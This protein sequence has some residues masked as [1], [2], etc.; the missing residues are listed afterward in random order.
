MLFRS[1]EMK[2]REGRS[3]SKPLLDIHAFLYVERESQKAI[4]IGKGGQRLKDVG[5]RARLSIERLLGVPVFLD[6]RVKIA[7][8]WQRDPKQLNRLGF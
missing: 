1:E 4:V 8:D 3:E 5:Q 6:L 2:L 7:Q